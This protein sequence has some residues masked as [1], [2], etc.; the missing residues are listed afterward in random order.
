MNT[1]RRRSITAVFLCLQLVALAQAAPQQVHSSKVTETSASFVFEPLDQWKAAVLAGDK[2]ALVGLYTTNPAARAKTPRGE[3]LDPSEEPMFWSSLK[4]GGLD[5]LDIKVLEARTLQPGVMALVLRIEAQ[6]KTS[7]GEKSAVISCAQVW[8]QKLGDWKIISTQ[9]GDLGAKETRRLPEPAKPNIQ[10]YPPPEEAPAEISS[11]LAA[12]ARDH[13]RVLMVFGG[14]WCYD[15]HVLDATF[16]SKS[17]AP[18][19]IANYHVIH[20]NI[21]NYDANL[22]LAKKYGV[23]LD[24][25]VPGLAVI[26][27]DG[28]LVTSQKQGEFESTVKIGP[29]D[30]VAFLQRWKPQHGS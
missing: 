11:A 20:I 30:V 28:K 23:P 14:N 2:A 25:G 19:V 7:Q 18:L 24:K 22:D 3:T 1:V 8:V 27:S 12:A 15:C 16:R 17:I 13:K 4:P 6:L 21:G 10:L 5:R 26:D 29:E 9:R